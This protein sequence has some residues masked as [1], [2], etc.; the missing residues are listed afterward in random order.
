MVVDWAL[1]HN[2]L[3]MQYLSSTL[4]IHINSKYMHVFSEIHPML[5]GTK[6]AKDKIAGAGKR[7]S[8][9]PKG[10]DKSKGK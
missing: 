5:A 4:E 3:I 9:R 2:T 8:G 10:K 1:L 6:A 7:P